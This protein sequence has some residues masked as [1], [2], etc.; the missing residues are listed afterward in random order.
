WF[1]RRALGVG[2]AEHAGAR[3]HAVQLGARRVATG[4]DLQAAA[5]QDAVRARSQAQH[6]E[7]DEL[8]T[9][10]AAYA[11]MPTLAGRVQAGSQRGVHATRAQGAQSTQ[12][13]IPQYD[14][15][16]DQDRS[17]YD[18]DVH[19]PLPASAQRPCGVGSA[20]GTQARPGERH[21]EQLER[22][23]APPRPG[24]YPGALAV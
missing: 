17:D 4:G 14:Q 10:V 15:D 16:Q 5:V 9:V 20:D 24:I 11:E 2:E 18:A 6:A 7:P 3:R 19:G 13:E 21:D 8:A 23:A 1:D 22:H 12:G